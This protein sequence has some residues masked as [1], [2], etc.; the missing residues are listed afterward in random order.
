VVFGDS[1]AAQW[2]PAFIEIALRRN[3]RVISLIKSACPAPA[4][5]T[6]DG[7][8]QTD[9]NTWRGR[10]F[11]LIDSLNPS[12][13]VT[14]SRGFYKLYRS[15]TVISPHRFSRAWRHGWVRTLRRLRAGAA[16]VVL[17][18]DAPHNSQNVVSCLAAH[19]SDM[20]R[21]VT[22]R[23][24]ATS[25]RVAHAERRAAARVGV[26]YL[27]TTP[28]VCPYDPCPVVIDRWLI[29]SD[30]GHIVATYSRKLGPGMEL[31]PPRPFRPGLRRAGAG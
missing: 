15:G 13:L 21:C 20:S 27:R 2:L 23:S 25:A 26:P 4:V 28:L 12:L 16:Q 22:S 18:A 30:R 9:C 1:H 29:L 17:L 10:A 14:S 8:P 31:L 11:N 3:W 19:P 7:A 5:T 24:L 6:W